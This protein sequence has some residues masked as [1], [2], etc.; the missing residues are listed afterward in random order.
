MS[1]LSLLWAWRVKY[2]GLSQDRNE[3][4]G[5]EARSRPASNLAPGWRDKKAHLCPPGSPG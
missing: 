2:W 1:S 4:P 3:A 5:K